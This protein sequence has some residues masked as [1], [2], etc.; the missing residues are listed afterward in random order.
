MIATNNHPS[1]GTGY[2]QGL[3]AAGADGR[4]LRLSAHALM[5]RPAPLGKQGGKQG[6]GSPVC[7]P[8]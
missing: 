2:A 3:R 7:P 8:V 4:V 5:V 6:D 1:S